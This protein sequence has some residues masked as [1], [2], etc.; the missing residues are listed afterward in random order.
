MT[1]KLAYF[2]WRPC[3]VAENKPQVTC[4]LGRGHQKPRSWRRRLLRGTGSGLRQSARAHAI[5]T[6]GIAP[7]RQQSETLG[8]DRKVC[9]RARLKFI[10]QLMAMQLDGSFRH[11]ELDWGTSPRF[12]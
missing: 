4:P 5:M 8:D 6:R 2:S 9:K 1:D 12:G 3:I 10:G 7:F 11:T